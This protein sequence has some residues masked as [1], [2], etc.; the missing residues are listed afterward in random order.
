MDTKL[1]FWKGVLDGL[2]A[3]I[4]AFSPKSIRSRVD[5]KIVEPSY[6][7]P[8]EDRHNIRLYFE[9]AIKDARKE[10]SAAEEKR[11]GECG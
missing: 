7:S 10:V 3:P 6:R 1:A 5:P 8:E 11:C 9:K 4:T 2:S